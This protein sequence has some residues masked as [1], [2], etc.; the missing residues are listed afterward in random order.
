MSS[1]SR[2][3][4]LIVNYHKIRQNLYLI[5]TIGSVFLRTRSS[6]LRP[7]IKRIEQL[8]M[9]VSFQRQNKTQIYYSFSLLRFL[10]ADR[11]NGYESYLMV[12]DHRRTW[13][14]IPPKMMLTPC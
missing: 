12:N 3:L 4:Y 13:T 9:E 11:A 7:I 1:L 6:C 14:P 8:G 10:F 2:N 5:K